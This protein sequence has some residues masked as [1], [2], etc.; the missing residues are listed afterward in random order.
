MRRLL[1][2]TLA[3]FLLAA[4]VEA[5]GPIPAA[6][7]AAQ[8]T[9][10]G[11]TWAQIALEQWRADVGKY[12]T[13]V[14]Y[15]GNGSSAGRQVYTQNNID[16]AASEI[17]FQPALYDRNGILLYD[18]IKAAAHRPY[19]YLPDVAG[20]TSFMYHLD[21]N[22]KRIT[23]LHLSGRTLAK[24]FTGQIT[25]WNDP[26]IAADDGRHFPSTRITPIVRS[27]GS[28]T[29]AQ[30]TLYMSSVF[31]DIWNPFCRKYL[32]L[33]PCPPQTSLYPYFPGSQAQ[34]GSDGVANFVQAGYNNGAI[35]YVEYG[36]ATERR[37]PVVS[38]LNQAGYFRQPTAEN[39]AIALTR[40]KIHP[41][42]TQDLGAVYTNPDPRAY[43]ISSYS[44]LIVPTTTAAPMTK[45]KGKTLG[46]Y[47]L[48]A[49]CTGQQKAKQLG[50]SPLPPNV[51]GFAFEA[52]KRIPGAPAPPALKDCANPT[53]TG[54][55]LTTGTPLPPPSDKLG[56]PRPGITGAGG[57]TSANG[58]NASNGSASNAAGA[59]NS[60]LAADAT[61]AADGGVAAADDPSGTGRTSSLS[62][63]PVATKQ[64]GDTV[65]LGVYVGVAVVLLLVLFVPPVAFGLIRRR[66]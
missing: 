15:T 65:S 14:N 18:E 41:D 62:A 27:D 52:E 54:N 16:F 66:E 56:A 29:S 64:K 4:L 58:T 11:S 19:A 59:G 20:G 34:S 61:A 39:V 21:I 51:V 3:G 30:F 45:D 1:A 32:N 7:A 10:A 47:I 28:G 2:A 23:D 25:N 31:P 9:G 36:Y 63:K 50:Y 6:H 33:D 12:G 38:V 8:V 37:F 22:G 24:I 17:P 35:T 55:F 44:Y 53:I 48:Y 40:A 42:F 13:V 57:S 43:P 49:V 5:A 60:R 26:A 46:D